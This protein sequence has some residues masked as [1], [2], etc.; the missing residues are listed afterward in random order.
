MTVTLE[1]TPEQERRLEESAFRRDT[2]A[3]REV[4]LQAVEAT[5][6]KLLDGQ[7]EQLNPTEFR[8]YLDQLASDFSDA[9]PLSNEAVSRAGLYRDHL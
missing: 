7:A 5:V 9:P 4:L 1:L 2:E 6:P 8:A 3:V